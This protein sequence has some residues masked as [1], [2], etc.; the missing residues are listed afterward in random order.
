MAYL[1]QKPVSKVDL[2]N[3]GD[4]LLPNFEMPHAQKNHIKNVMLLH[5]YQV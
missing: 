1:A 4:V 3:H 2:R 5:W